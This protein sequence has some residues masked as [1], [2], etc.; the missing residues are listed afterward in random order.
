MPMYI[1][2]INWTDQG[3]RSLKESPE[4]AAAFG[5]MAEEM[6]CTL[7]G[8]F[9][10]MGRYDSISRITAPDDETISALTLKLGQMGNVRTETLRAYSGEEFARIV[11]KVGG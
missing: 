3:A 5:T 4:R 9:F 11:E 1:V 2:L 10:T 6:G 8:N 7:H